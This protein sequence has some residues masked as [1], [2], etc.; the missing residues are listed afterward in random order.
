MDTPSR[1][2]TRDQA[3]GRARD[4]RKS[5]AE[6][7]VAISHAQALERVSRE[8]GF[9]DW[10][11]AS[12]RLSNTPVEPFNVGDRVTGVYLKRRFSGEILALRKMAD[13]QA[14][15]VSLALDKAVDVS[16]FDSFSVLRHR[17]TGTVSDQGRSWSRT[18]DGHPHLVLER[19]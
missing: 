1:H 14:Y 16:D 5:L 13:G 15:S 4:L 8:L 19:E 12:A 3:K 10:N 17:I 7:G 18:S 2:M 6:E 11:T 9:R